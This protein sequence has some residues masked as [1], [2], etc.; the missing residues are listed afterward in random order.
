MHEGR[1]AGGPLD[2]LTY[3]LRNDQDV[4]AVD[5]EAE[6]A[7]LYVRLRDQPADAPNY[8]LDM[9]NDNLSGLVDAATGARVYDEDMTI[10]AVEAGYDVLVI[11][12]PAPSTAEIEEEE[13]LTD[14]E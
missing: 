14:G 9:S 1:F 2:G 12:G 5:P 8:A 3:E 7:W 10:S 13:V 6:V 11:P 4:L